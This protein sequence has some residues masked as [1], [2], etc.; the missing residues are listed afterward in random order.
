MTTTIL[1]T[2][3]NNSIFAYFIIVIIAI[4]FFGWIVF[5]FT[6]YSSSRVQN[7]IIPYITQTPNK[8]PIPTNAFPTS[9]N[10]PPQATPTTDSKPM[11]VEL[12]DGRDV[13]SDR[14]ILV[15]DDPTNKINVDEIL[16]IAREK[17]ALPSVLI[18]P[19]GGS[20]V[21]ID[22]SQSESI[23]KAFNIF[24]Q[25]KGMGIKEVEY[26]GVAVHTFF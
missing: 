24:S 14:L 21:V 8:T 11:N 6:F 1:K 23:E 13:A 3:F 7:T 2:C 17:G 4:L 18:R 25:I 16:K 22:V 12:P 20:S 10:P 9:S 19:L 5:Y 15:L 26:D